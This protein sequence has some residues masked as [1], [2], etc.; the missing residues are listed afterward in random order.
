[1]ELTLYGTGYM[2]FEP[3]TNKCISLVRGMTT[4]NSLNYWIL[5]MP[6]YRN[7][8]IL[9]DLTNQRMGFASFNNSGVVPNMQNSAHYGLMAFSSV[10]LTALAYIL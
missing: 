7:F 4:L 2:Y 1:M 3:Q 9:H 8:D 10:V 6:F 5:G